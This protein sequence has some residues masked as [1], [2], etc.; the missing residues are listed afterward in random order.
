MESH[1]L[2][3]KFTTLTVPRHDEFVPDCWA[4]R[5]H[6]SDSG[7][8]NTANERPALGSQDLEHASVWMY[9]LAPLR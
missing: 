1:R 6:V 8:A 7:C 3:S 4:L 2:T 9:L 5:P